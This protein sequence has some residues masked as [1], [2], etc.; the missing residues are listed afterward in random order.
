MQ[1]YFLF[2]FIYLFIF[3][4]SGD[5]AIIDSVNVEQAHW[6]LTRP[7]PSEEKMVAISFF[8]FFLLSFV[9]LSFF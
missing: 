6:T 9:V 8:F 2:I 1:A 4:E 3:S 5:E 7:G